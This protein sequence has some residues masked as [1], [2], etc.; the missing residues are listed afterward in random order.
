MILGFLIVELTSSQR[1]LRENRPLLHEWKYQMLQHYPL[2]QNAIKSL[3]RSYRLLSLRRLR[4]SH[5]SSLKSEVWGLKS[6]VWSLKS[7]VWSLKSLLGYRSTHISGK[8]VI[9]NPSLF[10]SMKWFRQGRSDQFFR[11]PPPGMPK[12]LGIWEWGCPK[13][14]HTGNRSRFSKNSQIEES[15][16]IQTI[17]CRLGKVK[18]SWYDWGRLVYAE[19]I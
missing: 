16:L 12:T 10:P 4:Y 2:R 8:F 1:I 14:C 11:H 5:L 15:Q 19:L 9:D 17:A 6:E 3:D 13:R 7:E 18:S